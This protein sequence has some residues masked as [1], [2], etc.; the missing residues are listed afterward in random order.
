M[1]SENST[2]CTA[3]ASIVF[4]IIAIRRYI[5]KYNRKEIVRYGKTSILFR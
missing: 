5:I 3:I 2:G 4:E 1:E